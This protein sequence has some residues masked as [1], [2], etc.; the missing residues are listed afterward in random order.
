MIFVCS[1]AAPGLVDNPR[2]VINSKGQIYWYKR[3]HIKTSCKAEFNETSTCEIVVG[4][5]LLN[6]AIIDFDDN[7]SSCAVTNM[8][9]AQSLDVSLKDSDK[10]EETR[11]LKVNATF[12]DFVCRFEVTKAV[13]SRTEMLTTTKNSQNVLSCQMY[14]IYFLAIAYHLSVKLVCV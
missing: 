5:N 7:T 10:R 13:P 3:L 4:S 14:I 12:P 9:A 8:V 6:D 11:W 1:I 2:I